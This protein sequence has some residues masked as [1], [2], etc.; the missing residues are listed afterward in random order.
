ME[1]P[2]R[3]DLVKRT[4]YDFAEILVYWK[5]PKKSACRVNDSILSFLLERFDP[6][7]LPDV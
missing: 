1:C 4:L 5:T 2:E 6:F 7:H 3:R